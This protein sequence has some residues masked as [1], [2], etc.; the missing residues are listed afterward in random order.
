MTELEK[1]II[2]L[3]ITFLDM[4]QEEQYSLNADHD[5]MFVKTLLTMLLNEVDDGRSEVD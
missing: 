1:N 4:A 2:R 5:R 3:A